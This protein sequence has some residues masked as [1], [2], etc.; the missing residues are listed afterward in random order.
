M[1]R[2]ELKAADWARLAPLLRGKVGDAGRST[3]DDRLFV[4]AVRWIARSGAPWRDLPE[5][6]RPW[7]SAYRRF[8]RRAQTGVWQ[9]VFDAVQDPDPDWAMLDLTSVRA[10]QHAAGPKKAAPQP[11]P[12]AVPA[13]ALPASSTSS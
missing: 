5:R 11:K 9:R 6:F 7:N 2:Y 12:S 3:A 4:N 13:G 10:H 1:R 8:R